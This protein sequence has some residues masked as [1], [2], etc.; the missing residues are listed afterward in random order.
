MV[1][2]FQRYKSILDPADTLFAANFLL[3]YFGSVDNAPSLM[4]LQKVAD[5]KRKNLWTEQESFSD[6]FK[7]KEVI[8][9][10]NPDFGINIYAVGAAVD[11]RTK[12]R[13]YER[14]LDLTSSH[15]NHGGHGKYDFVEFSHGISKHTW[16]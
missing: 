4:R 13:P 8:D 3:G 1:D 16:Y 14:L 11:G 5:L 12:K 7:T 2:S 10:S 6:F 9:P 15:I